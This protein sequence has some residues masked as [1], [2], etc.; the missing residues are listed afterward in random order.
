[1]WTEQGPPLGRENWSW[2]TLLTYHDGSRFAASA[3]SSVSIALQRLTERTL[4]RHHIE[5]L[6]VDDCSTQ[7]EATKL[8]EVT[9]HLAL[10]SCCH[11]TVVRLTVNGG[12]SAARY[13]GLRMARRSFIHIMDQD[14]EVKPGFYASVLA[15]YSNPRGANAEKTMWIAGCEYIDAT[16]GNYGANRLRSDDVTTRR[17]NDV[18]HWLSAGNQARSPGMVVL[19]PS[20]KEE[21]ERYFKSLDRSV[22]G[23][24]DYWMFVYLLKKGARFAIASEIGLRYRRHELNQS[25]GHD[26]LASGQRGLVIMHG[27]GVVS[28]RECQMASVRYRLQSRLEFGPQS[29][30]RKVLVCLS[31]PLAA[32]RLFRDRLRP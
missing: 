23:S 9:D 7:D 31:S 2:T 6:V 8:R 26:F 28:R 11:L 3:L 17:L 21:A 10:P 29:R 4:A 27:L 18:N 1:M 20:L 12:V 14:D 24:D 25:I 22:D 19:S 13:E 15:A 5:L 30:M 16:G 32:W